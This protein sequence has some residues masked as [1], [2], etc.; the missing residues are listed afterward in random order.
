[1]SSPGRTGTEESAQ[2]GRSSMPGGGIARGL[3]YPIQSLWK[4]L[5]SN[6]TGLAGLAIVG[7]FVLVAIFADWVA[8]Y[9]PVEILDDA[10]LQ[11]PSAEFWFGTDGNAMDIFSRTIHASRLN[12]WI[13]GSAVAVSFSVGVV[14]GLV[15]GY[16]GGWFDLLTVR[17]M[18]VLQAMPV[19][20]LALALV[21]ATGGLTS[22]ILVIAFLDAPI[23]AR[24]I[25]GEVVRIREMQYVESARAVG[26]GTGRMLFRHILPNALPPV[27][28]QTAI[29]MA[30]AVK[31]TAALAFVGVGIQVPTPEWG[32]MIRVGSQYI[33]SGAWWATLFPGLAVVVLSLGLNLLADGAQQHMDPRTR[34]TS[35]DAS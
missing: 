12:L 31:I 33:L 5:R 28:V 18:D 24:L 6:P 7:C 23:Y 9:S 21:G 2:S 13:A 29:R 34:R 25:R 35:T 30:W 11:P 20:I 14:L 16:F 8:P 15:S 32:S 19:L 4:F 26:N 17:S 27:L 10:T 22:V 1:M 3:K